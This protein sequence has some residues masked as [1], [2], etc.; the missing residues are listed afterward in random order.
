[1]HKAEIYT[2]RNRL[3][4]LLLVCLVGLAGAAQDELPVTDTIFQAPA[5]N[6]GDT[7]FTKI[8]DAAAIEVRSVPDSALRKL[9]S[10]AD[11]WYVNTAPERQ[12]QKRTSEK[13]RESWYQKSWFTNLLW[14]LVL[15]IFVGILIWFLASSNIKL[16]RKKPAAIAREDEEINEENIFSLHYEKEIEKAIGS[17]NYRLAIRLWYLRILKELADR[18]MIRYK[19]GTTNSEYVDQLYQTSYH[20]EFSNLTRIFEYIWYGKFE[21]TAETFT[22]LQKDFLA[23]NRQLP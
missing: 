11:Y 21:L 12:K 10:D 18:N 9:R 7:A 13:Q 6:D 5:S 19:Q 1:M 17:Q 22:L 20:N 8:G 4:C 23:F 2:S 14:V 16:F 15:G 3:F